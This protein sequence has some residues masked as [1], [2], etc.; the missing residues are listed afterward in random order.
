MDSFLDRL[1]AQEP[2]PP[3]VAR[4]SGGELPTAID[5]APPRPGPADVEAPTRAGEDAPAPKATPTQDPS[6]DPPLGP[7]APRIAIYDTLT[8]PPRV[9]SVEER[10]IPGLIASLAEKTYHSC[11]E[12]GGNVPFTVINE[13]I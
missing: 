9:V 4:R 10:D 11:R 6:A 12:Q 1:L 5:E 3:S 2:A 7:G 13:L 8:S